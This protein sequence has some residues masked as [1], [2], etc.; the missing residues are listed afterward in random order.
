[1]TWRVES[2]PQEREISVNSDCSLKVS[3]LALIPL[4]TFPFSLTLWGCLGCELSNRA[5]M[6]GMCI[7]ILSCAYIRIHVFSPSLHICEGTVSSHSISLVLK[8]SEY[9]CS[10]I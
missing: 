5:I 3:F 7:Y 10:H 1:M 6:L 9:N 4:H 2:W 8:N